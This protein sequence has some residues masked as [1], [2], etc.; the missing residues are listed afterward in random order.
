MLSEKR[1]MLRTL[2]P[3]VKL[4]A[5]DKEVTG[6]S[7]ETIVCRLRLDRTS[8]FPGPMTLTLD[9]PAGSE[10]VEMDETVIA[11]GQTEVAVSVRVLQP[12]RSTKPLTLMFRATGRLDERIEVITEASVTLHWQ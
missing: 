3:V 11:A 7:G 6:Q 9:A 2:P 10:L 5:V 8:N 12:P 1:N 4:N